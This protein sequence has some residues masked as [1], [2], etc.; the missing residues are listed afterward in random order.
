MDQDY[1]LTRMVDLN[2]PIPE[3]Q[4]QPPR[5]HSLVQQMFG[6]PFAY[7]GAFYLTDA[8]NLRKYNANLHVSL[9]RTGA[10]IRLTDK[11]ALRAGRARFVA[12][13]LVVSRTIANEPG[14]YGFSRSTSLATG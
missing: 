8:E 13:T 14:F 9:T 3:F 12:P 1:R 11:M 4:S 10:S 6:K 2:D 7:N 5:F